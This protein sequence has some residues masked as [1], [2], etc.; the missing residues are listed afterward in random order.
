MQKKKKTVG[1]NNVSLIFVYLFLPP[2]KYRYHWKTTGRFLKI[3]VFFSYSGRRRTILLNSEIRHWKKKKKKIQTQIG[4]ERSV[5][6]GGQNQQHSG[7]RVF[8]VHRHFRNSDFTFERQIRTQSK[9]RNDYR[10]YNT[11]FRCV[12]KK[13]SQYVLT[14]VQSAMRA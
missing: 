2:L 1:K 6:V 11:R 3:S 8:G 9:Y 5:S 10:Y 7:A 13:N 4:V 14:H 12:E